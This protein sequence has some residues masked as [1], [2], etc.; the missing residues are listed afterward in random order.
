MPMTETEKETTSEQAVPEQEATAQK[1]MF[2][3][4]ADMGEEAI[5]KLS[6]APGGDR[7]AAAASS[8]RARM[9]EMQKKIRG[10]DALE[11]RVV[12]LERKVAELRGEPPPAVTE[13][14]A[15]TSEPSA[16]DETPAPER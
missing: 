3:R 1:D 10:L 14:T 7:L 6:G 5:Q 12:E 8:M 2:T 13:P 9:D 15:T 11:K 4:L 16:P